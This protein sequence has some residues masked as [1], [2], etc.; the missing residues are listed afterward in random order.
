M[1]RNVSSHGREAVTL[2]SGRARAPTHQT[3]NTALQ[4]CHVTSVPWLQC[5]TTSNMK[6]HTRQPC[7]TRIMRHQAGH[8]QS[9]PNRL[10]LPP[11]FSITS[12]PKLLTCR[13][14][15]PRLM[16]RFH[17]ISAHRSF[18]F[19]SA[20]RRHS[21]TLWGCRIVNVNFSIVPHSSRAR[22]A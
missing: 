21:E 6:Q 12:Q 2:S 4:T 5:Q 18:S 19:L 22:V 14:K 9:T 1:D 11:F 10:G 16:Q 7:E 17:W 20:R 8:P 15:K 3:S 13:R